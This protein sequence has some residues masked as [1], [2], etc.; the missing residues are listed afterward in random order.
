MLQPAFHQ[1]R[2]KTLHRAESGVPGRSTSGRDAPEGEVGP[3]CP[4]QL[5]S[6]RLLGGL[7]G[8][9]AW[10]GVSTSPHQELRCQVRVERPLPLSGSSSSRVAPKVGRGHNWTQVCQGEGRASPQRTCTAPSLQRRPL[11]SRTQRCQGLANVLMVLGPSD[12]MPRSTGPGRAET[13][14][15]FSCSVLD[16]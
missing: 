16:V 1:S 13:S 15:T 10:P 5:P 3:R 2:T 14:R 12:S 4:Q 6:W 9:A 8:D 11:G 7:V